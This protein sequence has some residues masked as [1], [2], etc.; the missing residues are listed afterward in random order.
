MNIEKHNFVIC[1]NLKQPLII[2]LYIA[3]RYKLGV[4]W[5]TLHL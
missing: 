2:G 3:Q 4:D 5:D 1:T